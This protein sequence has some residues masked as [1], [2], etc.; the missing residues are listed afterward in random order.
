MKH[1]LNFIDNQWIPSDHGGSFPVDNPATGAVVASV[2]AASQA[3]ALRACDRAAAAQRAWRRL[4]SVERGVHLHALADALIARKD[5]IGAVLAL[6]SGKSLEDA[7]FEAV[8][9]GGWWQIGLWLQGLAQ[10]TNQLRGQTL[11]SGGPD[12]PVRGSLNTAGS[13]VVQGVSLGLE[14]RW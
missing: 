6:E 10:P 8:T 4:T 12:S 9:R 1:Y 11:S 14:G 5:A 7:T 3:Q 13:T 2:S